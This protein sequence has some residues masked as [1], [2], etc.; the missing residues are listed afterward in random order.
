MVLESRSITPLFTPHSLSE[1]EKRVRIVFF[2]YDENANGFLDCKELRN[3]LSRLGIDHSI[4]EA[5][6]I[7]AAYDDDPNGRL[8]MEE[9][10]RLVKDLEVG[11]HSRGASTSDWPHALLPAVACSLRSPAPCGRLL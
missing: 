4:E 7:L 9:W 5:T 2:E 1:G 11:A 3:A 6:K 8:D 10:T